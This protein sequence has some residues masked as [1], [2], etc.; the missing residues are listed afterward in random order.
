M[1]TLQLWFVFIQHQL[2]STKSKDRYIT[3]IS[4]QW[5][6]GL[7][8]S[9]V[10]FLLQIVY[11]SF[12]CSRGR[13]SR[14]I[15]QHIKDTHWD[16]HERISVFISKRSNT[17]N[18]FHV[19]LSVLASEMV[20]SKLSVII[21]L[22]NNKRALRNR[23]GY[24]KFEYILCWIKVANITRKIS[25]IFILIICIWS[26]KSSMRETFIIDIHPL[27]S[28]ELNNWNIPYEFHFHR[29]VVQ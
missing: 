3:N 23:L 24:I 8:I 9:R 5:N 17:K 27:H 28:F 12:P 1:F 2:V 10:A 4:N 29:Y 11:L 26:W 18:N 15:V 7:I 19:S 22:Q 13:V 16:G 6:I 21:G 25:Y 20:I 14:F